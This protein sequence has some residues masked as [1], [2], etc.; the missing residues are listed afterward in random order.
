L[1]GA[2]GLT[3]DNATVSEP[4]TQGVASDIQHPS[5]R[6]FGDY[7][8][9]EEIARGGMGIVYKAR[10]VSL[11]RIVAVKLLLLGRYASEEFIHRFRIE[12][13]AAASLRH[14]NIVAIHEVGVHQGQ[15]YFA[16]DFVD[17]PDL[18]QLARDQPLTA[19]R[20]AGYVKT[21]AEAIHFAHTRRILHRDLKPSNVLI[22]AT[23]QPRVTDFGLAKNLANDSDLTLTG[24]VLGSPSFMPPEQALGERGK[25]APA[26]DVYSLG[27]ILYHA[28]TGRPPF[29]GQT[30]ADTLQ[31][32]ENKQPI[33]PRL[34]IP[35]VPADL[36]TICLKCL[37]K[38]P[39]KRF[40]SGQKLSDE[41]GRFLRSE[42]IQSRPVSLPEK[43]WRWC[44]RKPVVASL[45][46]ATLALLM[47]L[48]VGAPIAAF[49]IDHARQELEEN[50]YVSDV[51]LASQA[52][53]DY[54]L[55][56]ARQRLERIAASPHQRKLRGWEWRYLMERCRGDELMTLGRHD[57]AVSGLAL[58]PH[59]KWA[60]SISEDGVVKIWDLAAHKEVIAWRAHTEP[61]K[62]TPSHP[63]HAVAF[64][65]D[66]ETLA[67]GGRDQFVRLW[68]GTIGQKLA[69]MEKLEDDCTTLA[70]SHDGRVLAAA[71]IHGELSLWSLSSNLPELLNRWETKVFPTYNL[72]LSPDGAHLATAGYDQRVRLWDISEPQTLRQLPA[73]D[74][75]TFPTALSP[76]GKWLVAAGSGTHALRR[77]KLPARQEGR[78]WPERHAQFMSLAFSRDGLV[79]ASGLSN[80]EIVLWDMTDERDPISLLGHEKY[81]LGLAF[82]QDGRTLIS[83]GWDK[84]VRLWDVSQGKRAE[85]IVRHGFSGVGVCFSPDSQYIASVARDRTPTDD[86]TLG[87]QHTLKLWQV[88]GI[89]EVTNAPTGGEAYNSYPTFSP[90]GKLLVVDSWKGLQLYAVPSLQRI[91]KFSGFHPA[92]PTNGDWM[93]IASG[94]RIVRRDAPETTNAVRT[95][96]GEL[97]S[98]IVCLALSPD[99]KIVVCSAEDDDGRGVQFWDVPGRHHLGTVTEHDGKVFNLAFS[100]DGKRFASAGWDGKIGIW[101]VTRRRLVK[102]L[103]GDSGELYGVAFSPDGRTLVTSG[104]DA[105]I[106]LWITSTLQEVAVL[107]MHSMVQAVAFSPDGQW[108]AASA[109]GGTVHVWR[110]PLWTEIESTVNSR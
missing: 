27:A 9:L 63:G 13:S 36:E 40:E 64:S 10:Q 105:I 98:N 76:D 18:A 57:S 73:F 94:S 87:E 25:M 62:G 21:I 37:E 7:E 39:G 12:A 53:D 16:M 6:Y 3:P 102:L 33:A 41:L 1:T 88:S 45:G 101:D 71:S 85:R 48:A 35:S 2:L 61:A 91:T 77:W 38:E 31:Q 24:Q 15:H 78:S 82:S 68:K 22:D 93:V 4:E 95:V 29:M 81:V 74:G 43:I 26:S 110:A 32:V 67:T 107:R 75:T 96:I 55:P 66:G 46:T 17:G 108:L 34:L 14:P 80:G 86:G 50:L 47:A 92:F 51:R 30:V 44:R 20:A 11:D 84:T 90:D 103:R 28:L 100:P 65:P 19:K 106:R 23:D 72:V 56:G 58:S 99:G 97:S 109:N 59:G 49:R 60:A 42:P 79:L 54:D 104:S 5:I 70:F 69:E 83:A 89:K 8:L 52:L